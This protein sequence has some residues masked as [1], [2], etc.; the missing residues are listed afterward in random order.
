LGGLRATYALYF[1][2]IGKH[3]VDYRIKRCYDPAGNCWKQQKIIKEEE[4][5][6]AWQT[7][8]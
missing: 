3:L 7:R 8:K 4:I 5:I 1:R 2:L 6:C